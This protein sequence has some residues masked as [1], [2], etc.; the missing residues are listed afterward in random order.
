MH[1]MLT[2]LFTIARIIF[3]F[4]K[5]YPLG[6]KDRLIDTNIRFHSDISCEICVNEREAQ[7][8]I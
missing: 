6:L 2:P 4:F 8:D 5:R 3:R 1:K 7:W